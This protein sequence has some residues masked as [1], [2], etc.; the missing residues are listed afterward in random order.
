VVL[1]MALIYIGS[2]DLLASRHT[3]RIIGP[4]LRFFYPAITDDAIRGV[5]LVVRKAGHVT[6]Y[7][8]LALLLLRAVS[9]GESGA[10]GRRVPS[11]QAL[12]RAWLLAT[13]YAGTD[14]FH[15]SF[16]STRDGSVRDVLID[17][18]GAALAL[19]CVVWWFRHRD[20]PR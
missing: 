17:S 13:A 12:T 15:Q 16:V 19:V 11:N 9:R 14:E 7:A 2:T 10:S 20:R 3:S 5:Q 18:F 6:E 4:V 8:I 1:W